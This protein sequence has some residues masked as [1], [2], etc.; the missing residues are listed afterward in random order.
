MSDIVVNTNNL[1]K[2]FNKKIVVENLCLRIPKGCIFG[3]LGP[4]GVGKTTTIRMLLGLIYPDNGTIEIFGKDI[5]S[6]RESI[7]KDIGA[8]VESPSFYGNLNAWEN[9]KIVCLMKQINTEHINATL[10]LVGLKDCAKKK[11]SNFSLG[12][13]QRLG[14]ATAIIGNPKLI[15]LDEPVNGLDPSG[16]HEIRT[17]IKSLA[18]NS[19]ITFLIS[20]HLLNEMELMA[21]KVGIIKNG[22]L[23]YQG[24]LQQLMDTHDR[25]ITLGVTELKKAIEYFSSIN[26]PVI[27]QDNNLVIEGNYTVEYISKKLMEQG[28]GIT[29]IDD[30][31]N[32]LEDI[33]LKMMN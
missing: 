11:V 7:L 28:I 21:D 5:S 1:Q 26:I 20:S 2:S 27:N 8:M 3:L 18:K 6:N 13:K 16:I 30:K 4:N 12:M 9:L 22:H 25:R 15:I 24:D 17:L 32:S 23:I 14:I 29:S 10:E 31:T 33:Y 19:Q